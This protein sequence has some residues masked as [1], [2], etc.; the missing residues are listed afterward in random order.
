MVNMTDL[1]KISDWVAG[2]QRRI[3]EF[4]S[5]HEVALYSIRNLTEMRF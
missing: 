4:L 1:R 2:C 3:T 5:T